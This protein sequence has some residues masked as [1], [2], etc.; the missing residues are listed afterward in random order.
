M[1][2]E[3]RIIY[4]LLRARNTG[5]LCNERYH[6]GIAYDLL[7]DLKKRTKEDDFVKSLEDEIL[8]GAKYD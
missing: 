7:K 8:F 1:F 5:D 4:H 6:Y 2:R 3:F